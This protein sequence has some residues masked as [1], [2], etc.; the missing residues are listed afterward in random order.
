[1]SSRRRW[2]CHDDDLSR[3]AKRAMGNWKMTLDERTRAEIGEATR[4]ERVQ[5]EIEKE[6][7]RR[8]GC[9]TV[10]TGSDAALPR[11][12]L[13]VQTAV[14]KAQA[15]GTAGI[16]TVASGCQLDGRDR[17]RPSTSRPETTV[18]SEGH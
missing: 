10:A 13:A 4:R 6:R 17:L 3:Q 8:N 12:S 14:R 9:Q 1:M 7:S 18:G 11:G 2:D 15:G 16:S 5:K